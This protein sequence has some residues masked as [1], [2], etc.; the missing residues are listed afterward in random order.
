MKK[1]VLALAIAASAAA[2][3]AALPAQA[4]NSAQGPWMVRVRAVN[5]GM[6]NKSEPGSGALTPV[7]LPG[8]AI[9]ASDKTIPEADI[10]YFF[11][12]NLAAELILTVPQKHNVRIA[13]GPLAEPIGS[14]KHLPPT[15]TLQWHFL[16]DA[17]FR[18]YVGVG[19]NYT[20]ISNVNLR[21]T[22]A[23][24]T[25]TLDGSSTGPALQ[26]GF[27]VPFGKNM[28]FNVDVKKI[29]ISTDV[30]IGGAKVSALDLNPL[31][32]GVGIGWRF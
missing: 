5:L 27:D 20:K 1:K 30:K 13:T 17:A 4:Q 9:R 16:P 10:T 7:L 8:D 14:F 6:E 31:A 26:A 21:S 24:Q 2:A 22:I 18:P 32:V 29:Y 12:K 23:A 25:L 11:T 3:A 15:L 19:I 28:V